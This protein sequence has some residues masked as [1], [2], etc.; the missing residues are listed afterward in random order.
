MIPS[1]V[2]R[3]GPGHHFVCYADSCS[4]VPGAPHETTFAAVNSIVARLRPPPDFICFPGDEIS[5]LTADPDELRR[6]W[7]HWLDREM[8]WLDRS[9]IPLYHATGNH[10]TYDAV[11]ESVFREMLP[12]LPKNGPPGQEGLSYF[13]RRGDL[14]LVFVNTACSALGG[15]GRVETE[16][17]DRT[18]TDHS[19]ASWKLVVGHHPVFSVNGF[20]GPYQRDIEASNGRVFWQLLVRHKVFAYLCSHILAFDVQVHEGVLQLV[21]AG[22]GTATRMPPEQE[23]LHCV[24]AAL[25]GDGL[26]F[27]VLD[28]QG[29]VREWLDW[30]VAVSES[31]RWK[32]LAIGANRAPTVPDNSSGSLAAQ[33]VAWKFSGCAASTDDG[34]PQTLLS[35]LSKGSAL[36]P[37]WIGLAGPE[38]RLSMLMS[39]TAGRSPHLWH[40]PTLR[41][42]EP[43]S[44]QIAIH[45]GMGPGGLLWRQNDTSPWS[46]LAG[47]SPWGAERL[48]WPEK[49]TVGQ[50][51]R[52]LSDKPFRG[53]SLQARYRV[54]S[55]NFQHR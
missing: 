38:Q 40:G 8:A 24:Q 50:S 28:A 42:G 43:F 5:G 35:A 30:P 12:H 17:L 20:S 9:A 22:A 48:R 41:A 14:L 6:Q 15:E 11:S 34:S 21:T 1:L 29:R 52:G 36:A 18:L 19:D 49:W 3:N 26:H 16:W 10:T 25:D 33:F 23:Y 55:F 54:Q 32:A 53:T 45:T 31:S 46:S 47:A 7:R 13:V 37:L 39:H 2:P 4:G 27:Q 44:V 51:Q